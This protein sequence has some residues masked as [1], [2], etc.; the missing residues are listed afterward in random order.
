MYE[1]P[2]VVCKKGENG[3]RKYKSVYKATKDND[4]MEFDMEIF[5]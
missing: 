5:R 4:A 2:D 1:H 3:F